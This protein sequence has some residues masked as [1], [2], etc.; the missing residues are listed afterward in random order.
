MS[1]ELT[2]ARIFL[3][4]VLPLFEELP[5][6]DE[7]AKK[8]IK[9]LAG[10]ITFRAPH[11]LAAQ[12]EMKDGTIAV[13]QGKGKK[14]SITLYLPTVKMLNNLFKNKG[15]ALPIPV[16]GIWNI[17][18]VNA[19]TKLGDRLNFYMTPDPKRPLNTGETKLA[20][21]L[22]LFAAI[23]GAAPVGRGEEQKAIDK[24]PNGIAQFDIKGEP[25]VYIEKQKNEFRAAKGRPG[26]Y[27]MFMSFRDYDIAYK[28]F[29][30][31]L[32]FMAAIPMGDITLSGSLP[33]ADQFSQLMLKVG[34]YTQ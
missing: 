23:L 25:S 19:F 17:K 7:A 4:A 12:V 24:I 27:N 28:M 33:M 15:F 30:G 26:D 9:G 8:A 10:V 6:G 2:T 29:V 18:L 13:T 1:K 34:E 20:A 11:G 5:K 21:T 3:Q 31:K 32:D 22:L 14:S 16:W